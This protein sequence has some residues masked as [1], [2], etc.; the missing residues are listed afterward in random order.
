M[1]IAVAQTPGT[2]LDQWREILP[3]LDDLLARAAA[4]Q[5]Q[6]VVLPECVW[7]AYCLGRHTDYVAARAAGM[8]APPE[9]LQSMQQI[10]LKLRLAVCVGHVAEQGDTLL[11]AAS[12][13]DAEGRLLATRHKCF[14]W[15]FDHD[16]FAPGQQ[17]EPATAPWGR[18]GLMICADARLPEIPATL[19]AHA[20]QL[21]LQPTAWVNAGTLAAPWNPQPDFLIAARAAEFGVPIASASKWG[22][23]GATDFVGSSL[24][25]DSAGHI[26]A[27]C[28]AQ[29]TAV[30]AADVELTAARP[31]VL[32][33]VERATLLSP[34]EP[35]APRADVGSLEVVLL[36]A[37]AEESQIAGWLRR[38]ATKAPPRL[39]IRLGLSGAAEPAA[40]G[41]DEGVVVL[42][43]PLRE[44]AELAG[45]RIGAL[46]AVDAN[47]FAPVRC[48]ALHGAHV[49]VLFGDDAPLNLLQT[50]A[51]EN[52]I[53]VLNV[54][55]HG[56]CAIGPQG[57][58]P[59]PTSCLIRPATLTLHPADSASKLV[60]PQTDVLAGR[61][62][63]QYHF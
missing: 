1:R 45:I 42:N 62:P 48:L 10:A 37:G 58:A 25:C 15:A 50:R 29:E 12:L 14:L 22:R 3:L 23:E 27:Q 35:Q 24:I 33:A 11:N 17:I 8:P 49:V 20:V 63:A 56:S 19:A 41:S 9:F 30:V 2:R 21:L 43:G 59:L 31:P 53:C 18:V 16:Y 55:R 52:R 4:L 39:I 5:S 6:L 32:T 26:L 47:R 7:P 36:P 34:A 38:P 57:Y 54:H 44:L 61:R 46:A 13:I 51:C 28:E 60:A 40:C